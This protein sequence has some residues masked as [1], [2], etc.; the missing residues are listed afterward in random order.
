M[1]KVQNVKDMSHED[2]AALLRRIRQEGTDELASIEKIMSNRLDWGAIIK[3]IHNVVSQADRF[4]GQ[5]L[6]KTVGGFVFSSYRFD[7]TTGRIAI[8]GLTR[9]SGS[10]TFSF[11][12][13][14]IDSIEKS[15]KFKDIDYRSF[16]KTRDENG[17]FSSGINLEFTIQTGQ[18]TRSKETCLCP[19]ETRGVRGDIQMVV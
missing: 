14:L 8:S 10:N 17:D 1:M 11:I 3:D 15:P 9:T 4:Y 16:S 19:S 6:F 18:D 5:G 7:S 13:K 2:L 12:A